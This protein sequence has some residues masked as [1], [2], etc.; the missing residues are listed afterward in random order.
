MA[1]PFR[2][3]R[4]HVKP[5]LA[6]FVVMLMLSWVVGDSLVS[7]LSGSRNVARDSQQAARAIAVS[8]DGGSLTNQQI[9]ELVIRRRLLNAFLQQ[10]EMDGARTAYEAGVE[11]RPLHVQ[12]LLGPET[13]QQGVER[14]VVQTRLFADA[15]R[16]AGMRISDESI[17]QY[18]DELGRGN[19]TRDQMRTMLSHLQTSG[20]RVSIDDLMTL[21]REEM[22]ARNYINSNQYAFMT[23]TPEQRW[24]DWLRVNDRVVVEAAA[25]PTESSLVD[26]K[27]PTDAEVLEFFDKYK[28][29]ES[30]PELAYGTTELPSPTP[31]FRIPRKIDLQ[32]VEANY[33]SF[34]A[35]AEEKITDEEIAKYYE[36]HKDP[37]FVKADTGLMEDK[38]EKKDP[39]APDGTTPPD[40]KGAD[41]APPAD[42][43]KGTGEPE[44]T[45][46]APATPSDPAPA[47]PP[48]ATPEQGKAPDDTKPAGTDET[49]PPATEVK[50]DAPAAEKKQSSVPQSEAARVFH[51]VAFQDADK[52]DAPAADAAPAAE[53]S[54]A[55]EPEAKP[56]DTA[57]APPAAA[58]T[59]PPA[60]PTAP[61]AA[62]VPP[63]ASDPAAPAPP[64][65]V[66]PAPKKPLEFQPLDE[67][68]D[69]IRRLLAE[70]KVAEQLNA[71]ANDL[72]GQLEADF[73][74]YLAATLSAD[75]EEEEKKEGAKHEHPAPPKTLTDWAPLAEKNGLKHGETGPMSVLQLR[76]TPIGKSRISDSDRTLLSML[77]GGH[78]MELYQPVSTVDLD[79][80]HYIVAKKSD[81]PGR[82]PELAEVRDEV[83][84]AWKKQKASE[85]T[86]KR[87]EELAKKAE[88]AK[89][90]L[91]TFFADDQL[92]K[93][94]R[95]DP[96]AELTGG[97]VGVVNGQL[98]QQPYRL[99]QPA[100]IVA[101]G[102]DFMRRASQLKDG[103][104]A[105]VLNHDHSIAYVVRLVEH[106]PTLNELRTIYLTEANSWPGLDN[107]TRGHAQ[108]VMSNLENDILVG[109]NLEWK[110]DPDTIEQNDSQ[111][112][113]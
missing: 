26:V 31:G 113:G 72:Q 96:F 60:D 80:N 82:V 41:D 5:L 99:G 52:K 27:E 25:I 65:L 7:Y 58:A 98:Q 76:E 101:A 38:D 69:N 3:F 8:W 23:V 102:P 50:G 2:L 105:A 74:K 108:E 93:V 67:V 104:V 110:R 4:K 56:A 57:P 63:A 70:G 33:D 73:N 107:M 85:A 49:Q 34:L 92:I 106:Q 68:K 16:Q 109:S 95:T 11:P 9:N 13:P 28:N 14:S 42:A 103:E 87:A 66:P 39:A 17:V 97:D 35:K 19:V 45:P 94:V 24:R 62:T 86:L 100:D 36:A 53:S 15:A 20:G 84:K 83:V 22:L 77:F 78:E 51:L 6:V 64:A 88:E 32:F 1:S 21:L 112:A 12:R 40:A 71:L 111:D 10:V 61:P 29:R 44:K 90:P 81:T 54:K 30:S 79:G 91:T 59:T 47:T 37:M 48:P 43:A 55:S 89:S 75:A 46:P 18:L